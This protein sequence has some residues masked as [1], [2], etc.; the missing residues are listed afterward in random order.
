LQA[1]QEKFERWCVSEVRRISDVTTAIG[2]LQWTPLFLDDMSL[3]DDDF[4]E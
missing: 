2:I 4:A 1:Q 3:G